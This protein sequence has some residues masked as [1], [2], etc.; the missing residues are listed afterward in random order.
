MVSR[1][2]SIA[3]AAL[4]AAAIFALAPAS[5]D[6][7][8]RGG[9]RG[10]G[11][12][13]AAAAAGGGPGRLILLCQQEGAQVFVDEQLVGTVPLE[14]QMLGPGEHTVRVAQPGYTEFTDVVTIRARQD[15]QVEVEL[16]AV[17]GVVRVTSVPDGAQVFVD[18]QFQ[19]QAPADLELP[20]GQHSI[21][22]RQQGYAEA[23][24][25]VR[26]AAGHQAELEV[27]L[28]QLAAGDDPSHVYADP[29]SWYERPWTWLAIGGG[30]VAVAV[31]ITVIVLSSGG[32]SAYDQFCGS[33]TQCPTVF[34]P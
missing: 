28:E 12:G 23:I 13:G 16:I 22:V 21:R 32:P 17:S 26:V 1:R 34:G 14:P 2:S 24:R 20:E 11:R 31:T 18:G 9:G 25:N 29:K 15:S 6:A 8:R 33:P 4:A 10:A 27:R 19:G 30:A 7:Q 5:A 3:W